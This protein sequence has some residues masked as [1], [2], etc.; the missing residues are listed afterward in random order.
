MKFDCQLLANNARCWMIGWVDIWRCQYFCWMEL[1]KLDGRS[2]PS[3]PL[4]G[5]VR[6]QPRWF[7]SD[8]WLFFHTIF[9]K[10]RQKFFTV[11]TKKLLVPSYDT[12]YRMTVPW[13]LLFWFLDQIRGPNRGGLVREWKIKLDDQI[14][15]TKC[16]TNFRGCGWKMRWF[17]QM[18]TKYQV[19]TP[20]RRFA[21]D[22]VSRVVNAL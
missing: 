19:M 1:P 8:S 9:I 3:R 18:M 14:L 10:K 16:G 7:C 21:P 17:S 15:K 11:S 4:I 2:R 12:M 6:S 5:M 22:L 20:K 13:N